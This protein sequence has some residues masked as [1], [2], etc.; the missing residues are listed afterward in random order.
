MASPAVDVAWFMK[1]ADGNAADAY[2]AEL[3][4]SLEQYDRYLWTTRNDSTCF[5]LQ[6]VTMKLEGNCPPKPTPTP[7]N[8][9]GLLWSAGI[10]D[11][12][13]DGSTKFCRTQINATTWVNCTGV[14]L[15]MDVAGYSVDLRRSIARINTL[16]GNDADAKKWTAASAEVAARMKAALWQEDRSAMYNR[17]ADNTW[18]TTLVHSNLRMMWLGAF[19]QPMADAFV[20]DNLMNISRFWTK[21]PLPSIAVTDPHYDSGG[22]NNWSGPP[23]GLTV[24]RTLRALEAYG[25]H[26]ESMLVGVALTKALLSTPGCS[27]DSS[28]CQFSQQID[29]QTALPYAGDGYGSVLVCCLPRPPTA[30]AAAAA[31]LQTMFRLPAPR[32]ILLGIV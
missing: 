18:V 26:V 24:Q 12:G 22:S 11:S 30:A 31:T 5:G 21:M 3:K 29:P 7:A 17:Y 13:E 23:E 20:K 2:L 15:S 1:L 16:Q 25:H 32:P 6:N 14:F 28:K 19:T 27:T 4:A 8:Q 9:H 10:G